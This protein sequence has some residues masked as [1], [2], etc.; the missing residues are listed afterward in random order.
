MMI[1]SC[2]FTFTSVSL[3]GLEINKKSFDLSFSLL[4]LVRVHGKVRLKFVSGN[5]SDYFSVKMVF[6]F[7]FLCVY[8]L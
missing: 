8:F 7:V 6:L 3:T 1:V 5:L 4:M 2:R